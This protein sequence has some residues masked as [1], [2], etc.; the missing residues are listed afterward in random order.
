MA[1]DAELTKIAH[2]IAAKMRD[3]HQD[4]MKVMREYMNVRF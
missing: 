1:T 2:E 4:D 3:F